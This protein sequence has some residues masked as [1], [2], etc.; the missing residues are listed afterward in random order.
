[1]IK[2]DSTGFLRI[3]DF[4]NQVDRILIFTNIPQL[5][6]Y[7]EDQHQRHGHIYENDFLQRRRT[8]S[9]AMIKNSSSSPSVVS[10]V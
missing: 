7:S 2:Q 3:F 10:V 6:V 9:H 4:P 5:D 1:M 8:P